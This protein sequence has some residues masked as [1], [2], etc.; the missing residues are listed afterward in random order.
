MSE[1]DRTKLN[2]KISTDKIYQYIYLVILMGCSD[3]IPRF[4]VGS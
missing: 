2:N 1:P 4:D 3:K